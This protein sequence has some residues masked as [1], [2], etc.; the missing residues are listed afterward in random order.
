MPGGKRV[1]YVKGAPDRVMPMCSGQL[2]GDG[3]AHMS[4]PLAPLEKGV[5]EHAQ[6]QLSSK[7][8]R[9]LALCRYDRV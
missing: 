9:V 3:I 6:E 8:L 7:G 1:L 2:K 5:W 4:S